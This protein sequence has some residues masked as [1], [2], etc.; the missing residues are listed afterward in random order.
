MW[1]P[2]ATSM[3]L[4]VASDQPKIKYRT[5]GIIWHFATESKIQL[6]NYEL[7][8]IIPLGHWSLPDMC[9]IDTYI[10]WSLLFSPLSHAGLP[11]SLKHTWFFRFSFSYG[12]FGNFGIR[13]SSYPHLKHFGGVRSVCMLFEWPAARYFP[14]FFL[15]LL[16]CFLQNDW[17][18]HKKCTFSGHSLLSHYFCH[19]L[20]LC[21][22]LG[23]Q[24]VRMKYIKLFISKLSFSP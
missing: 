10:F 2:S 17:H 6:V 19:N 1:Y 13:W 5:S 18:L 24:F 21:Q 8:L 4:S 11:F 20:S 14:F 23:S 3:Y 9:A 15:I 7:S 22:Y 16:N 12:G